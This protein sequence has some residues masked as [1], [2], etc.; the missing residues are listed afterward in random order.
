MYRRIDIRHC[1]SLYLIILCSGPNTTDRPWSSAL[2][3]HP[4]SMPSTTDTVPVS[5]IVALYILGKVKLPKK[6]LKKTLDNTNTNS[7]RLKNP[8]LLLV[9]LQ[10]GIH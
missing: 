8:T 7:Y 1:W 6:T 10:T 2:L 9:T 3:P 4:S 5:F